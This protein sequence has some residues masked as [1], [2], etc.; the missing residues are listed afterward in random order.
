[1]SKKLALLGGSQRVRE[2]KS[3][4]D[5]HSKLWEQGREVTWEKFS[6]A[7]AQKFEAKYALP[8]SSGTTAL[9]SALSSVGAGPGD[10][11]IVPSFTW[12]QSVSPIIGANAIPAFADIDPKTFTLDP[13][14]VKEK[15]TDRT[16]AIIAVDIYG[17]PSPIFELKKIAKKIISF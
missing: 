2:I 17:H 11:V 15:I 4:Y 8:M 7:C 9:M 6:E 14:S 13:K 1:M 3:G 16:K 12:I 10:E 5:F